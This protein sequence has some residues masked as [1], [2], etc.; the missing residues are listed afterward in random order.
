MEPDLRQPGRLDQ[1]FEI[2][3]YRRRIQRIAARP[4][5]HEVQ[6]AVAS[7]NGQGDPA[8]AARVPQLAPG[9]AHS[10]NRPARLR[11]A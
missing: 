11:S 4:A 5:E 6:G 2:P 3:A 10:D 8:R 9:T 1:R 7:A